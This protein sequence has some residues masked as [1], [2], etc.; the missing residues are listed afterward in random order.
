MRSIHPAIALSLLVGASVGCKNH[1]SPPATG[2]AQ[3]ELT[4]TVAGVEYQLR[5]ARFQIGPPANLTLM[6]SPSD[7]ALDVDL[8]AGDYQVTLLPGWQMRRRMAMGAFQDVRA[9]LLHAPTQPFTIIA[10]QTTSILYRFG[11]GPEFIEFGRGRGRI[12]IQVQDRLDAGG[13]DTTAP[14]AS[15]DSPDAG[16]SVGFADC[17]GNPANGCETSLSTTANCAACGVACT[18]PNA[19]ATCVTGVCSIASCDLG[20]SNCDGAGVNGCELSHGQPA[21]SCAGAVFAGAASGDTSCGGIF[22]DGNASF[23]VFNTSTGAKS[24]FFRAHVREDSSCSARLEHRVTLD[25]PAG[26]DYDLFVHTAC[27]GMLLGASTSGPGINEMVTVVRGDTS[28]DDSFD[29]IVEVRF[30]SGATCVPWTLR[31]SGHSC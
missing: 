28:A 29:Y 27:G 11:V 12:S 23:S 15:A 13:P 3:F 17:D 25:V 10:G 19:T 18:R 20:F 14:D 4:T 7:P 21:T 1:P 8:V 22:C 24:A 2:R 31:F 9:V 6:S 26:V 16:C 5:D 30:I